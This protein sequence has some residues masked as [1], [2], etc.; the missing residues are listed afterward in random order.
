MGREES[1][2]WRS[3]ARPHCSVVAAAA[4]GTVGYAAAALRR[5]ADPVAT[6]TGALRRWSPFRGPV[7]PCSS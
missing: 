7:S 5:A 1:M 6:A 3:A 2:G 4:V